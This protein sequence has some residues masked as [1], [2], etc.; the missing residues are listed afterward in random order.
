MNEASL[1]TATPAPSTTVTTSAAR[2]AVAPPAPWTFPEPDLFELGNGIRGQVF[3]TP[4]QHVASVV[5][6]IPAP[7]GAEPRHLEGVGAIMSRTLDEGTLQHATEEFAELLERQGGVL[8]A[9]ISERGIIVDLE[10]PVRRLEPAL[11]LLREALLE[12]AFEETVVRRQ[13]RT[14]LAE[15]DQERAYPSHRAWNEFIHCYYPPESRLSRPAY[16]GPETVCAI[17]A[18]DVRA[19]HEA[20][21]RPDEATVVVAG[22]LTGLDV[23]HLVAETLGSWSATGTRTAAPAAPPPPETTQLVV[24]DRPGSVQTEI[25]VGC[26]GP[27]R[28]IE[29]PGGGWAPYPVLAYLVGGASQA[30]IDTVLRE[31]KGYTYGLRSVFRPRVGHG[32]FLTSGAVRTEVTGDALTLLLGILETARDGFTAEETAAGVDFIAKTA[33]NRYATADAIADEATGRA[34]EGLSTADT[35]RVLQATAALSPDDLAL[36][37]RAYVDG[38]WTVVLVGDAAAIVPQLEGL[39]RGEVSVVPA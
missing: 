36:A 7:F 21:V 17:T 25:Y 2:P 34:L 30:R 33:P 14:R 10:V 8:S 11:G 22:H 37:Y 23:P 3:D 13:V 15:I 12:P 26:R 9:G 39:G 31:E 20:A 5:V 27:H 35:T 32:L 6:A 19:Y 24:V 38:T 28:T 18:A 1:S 4:G 29:G 16:G